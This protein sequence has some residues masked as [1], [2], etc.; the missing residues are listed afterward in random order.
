MNVYEAAHG[1]HI[2]SASRVF[3]VNPVWQPNV[4]AQAIKRAHRIGQTRPVYVETLILKDTL[5]DQ[6]LQ[7]RK[8]MTTQE[9]QKAERGPL[10]D[11]TMSTII[12]HAQFILLP[13]DEIHDTGKQIARLEIPQQLFARVGKGEGVIDDPDA[14]LIFTEDMPLSK[15]EQR[16][17]DRKNT[18]NAKEATISPL[19]RSPPPGPAEQ[20]NGLF[21]G[22]HQLNDVS[23]GA[24]GPSS[25]KRKIIDEHAPDLDAPPSP[26]RRMPPASLSHHNVNSST[27]SS[28]NHISFASNSQ[29]DPPSLFGGDSSAGMSTLKRKSDSEHAPNLDEQPASTRRMSPSGLAFQ[30]TPSTSG[31]PQRGGTLHPSVQQSAALHEPSKP[32]PTKK[33]GFA[34]ETNEIEPNHS[35]GGGNSSAGTSSFVANPSSALSS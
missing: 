4:E 25:R 22:F 5:E 28:T 12:K 10:D 9:H 6:M 1:L 16:K 27:T 2:A 11:D 31:T 32:R 17:H 8:G 7:R 18:R 13:E 24:P 3:F 19:P 20:A 29:N 21:S 30:S 26:T 14:D 34:L 35:I 33:V 15:K 23:T